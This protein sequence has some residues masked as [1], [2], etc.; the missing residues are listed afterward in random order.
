MSAFVLVV[1]TEFY[2]LAGSDGH[3]TIN[4]VPAGEY[5]LVA[6]H[7]RGGQSSQKVTVLSAGLADVALQLDARGF[8]PKDHKN[9]YGKDYKS[10]T[11]DR[12]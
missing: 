1:P 8:R 6:W 5:T 9:K 10:D 7:Q 2:T 3:F 4:D 12:Y 11:G